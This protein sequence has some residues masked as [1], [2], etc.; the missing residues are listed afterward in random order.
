[1]GIKLLLR[2]KK[3]DCAYRLN[4]IR[5]YGDA[6]CVYSIGRSN[7][8]Y[9]GKRSKTVRLLR[10]DCTTFVHLG[11]LLQDNG[12]VADG[13]YRMN[14]NWTILSGFAFNVWIK[15]NSIKNRSRLTVKNLRVFVSSA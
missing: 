2:H 8:Q 14:G 3:V 1:M 7:H 10:C 4:S 6:Q 11:N 15:R 9:N 12:S 13:L 5:K